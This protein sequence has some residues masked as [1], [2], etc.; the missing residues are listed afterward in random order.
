VRGKKNRDAYKKGVSTECTAEMNF[1]SYISRSALADGEA[2]KEKEKK[3]GDFQ[4][5][6]KEEKSSKEEKLRAI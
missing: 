3:K 5:T 1:G 2:W 4:K 6:E